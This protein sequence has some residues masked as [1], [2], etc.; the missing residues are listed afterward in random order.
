MNDW[1]IRKEVAEAL[2]ILCDDKG[3][4]YDCKVCG[5]WMIGANLISASPQYTVDRLNGRSG[6]FGHN[7]T[8]H[9]HHN[10]FEYAVLYAAAGK[11]KPEWLD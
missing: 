6:V 10:A 4:Y 5:E 1:A 3:S 2:D 8:G 9:E 7:H 11:E